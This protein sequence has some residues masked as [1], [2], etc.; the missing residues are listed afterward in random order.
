MAGSEARLGRSQGESI[1]TP[2]GAEIR[3]YP[4]DLVT[5]VSFPHCD[6]V[7]VGIYRVGLVGEIT[8]IFVNG[9]ISD[10]VYGS[11]EGV[12]RRAGRVSGKPKGLAI[13]WNTATRI[14][15]LLPI[16]DFE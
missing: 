10:L 16:I 9:L 15:L 2:A 5:T 3:E 13:I 14:M 4:N 7:A 11:N 1:T 12:E 6:G 8:A